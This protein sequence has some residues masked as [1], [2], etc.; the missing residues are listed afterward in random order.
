MSHI[1]YAATLVHAQTSVDSPAI[2]GTSLGFIWQAMSSLRVLFLF[3][4]VTRGGGLPA[5]P[6]P[7]V[8]CVYPPPPLAWPTAMPP[9]QW[10]GQPTAVNCHAVLSLHVLLPLLQVPCV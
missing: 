5:I 3:L 9:T 1:S 7:Q 10:P 8:P 6:L 4:W 2:V